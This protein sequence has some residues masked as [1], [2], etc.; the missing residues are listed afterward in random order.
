MHRSTGRI[1]TTHIGSLPR[2]DDVRDLLLARDQG[3]PYDQHELADRVR[4][5]VLAAVRHQAEVGIDVVADGELGKN[6]FTNY[7]RDRLTGFEAVNPEPY[8]APPEAFPEYAASMRSQSPFS[9]VR[10]TPPLNVGPIAW[11]NRADLESDI[12]NLKAAVAGLGVVEAF[13]PA[14]SPGQVLFTVPT[15]YY[16]SD[17]EYL[18]ALAVVLRDEYRAIVDAGFI[19]QVDSPDTPMMRNRQLWNVPWTEYRRHLSMRL[20]ALNFALAGLPEERVRF[21]MCWGNFEGP[22]QN[23]VPLRDIVDLVLSVKAGAY[24]IEGANH[25]HAHEWEV[26]E[27]VRLP[28]GKLLIAGVIDTVSTFID[29]PRLVAQR[30]QRLADLV[31]RENVIA[32]PDCGFGTFAFRPPRV[33]PEIM[34]AKFAALV[35]GARIA[36]TQLWR[37]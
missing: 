29:H 37:R 7:I 27:Q 35:E 9:A 24:S 16:T 33:H 11:K 32:A 15:T 4:A 34:W 23:D 25:R 28:V 14:V 17:E 8:P 26:W 10:G 13:M 12:A 5:A 30:L 18:H 6:S 22:H 20:E 3:H 31:G 36:S 1:L 21:H 19:L 2:P